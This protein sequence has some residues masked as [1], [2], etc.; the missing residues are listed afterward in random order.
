MGGRYFCITAS[1]RVLSVLV[2]VRAGFQ[3]CQILCNLL[4]LS[5]L[6]SMLRL[7][8]DGDSQELVSHGGILYRSLTVCC[9]LLSNR[10]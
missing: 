6:P 3:L 9:C 8:I 10:S 1:L 7:C 4:R 2:W 5:W